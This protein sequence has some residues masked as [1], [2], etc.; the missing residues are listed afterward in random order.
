[1]SDSIEGAT[2]AIP[3]RPAAG[4]DPA[5]REQILDGAQCVFWRMGFD[6]ASMNDITREAGVSK[7]TLYVYFENKEDLFAAMVDRN[8]M[9]IVNLIREALEGDLPLEETLLRFGRTFATHLCSDKAV[10]GARMVLGVID[11]MPAL[12]NRFFATGPNS[13]PML[14]VSYIDRHVKAGNLAEG[15]DSTIAARQ[16]AEL[17]MAGL[18]RARLFGA[19]P[20]PPTEEEVERT[21]RSAVA[22]FLKPYGRNQP[23]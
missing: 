13:G 17:C 20:T 23:V 6:A 2:T 1:M 21:V 3:R 10:K 14:L 15:I 19:M 5:K 22:M 12:A 4:E 9:R 18:F 7:G 11:R 16:F 8:R